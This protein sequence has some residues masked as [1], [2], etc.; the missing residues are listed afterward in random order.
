MILIDTHTHLFSAQF[1][2]DRKEVVN[3]ALKS[4]VEYLLLPNIDIESID[5]MYDLCNEFPQNCLP[6]M[7]LHPGSVNENWEESLKIIEKNLF[8][9]KNIAVGEIGID[10][11]WDTSFKEFQQ[12]VFRIQIEWAKQLKLPIAIHTRQAFDEIFAIVDELNDDSL[13][14]VFHCFNGNLDRAKKIQEYGGFKLGIGGVLTYKKSGMDE[15]LKDIPL[16]MFVLETDSPYLSPTPFRGKRNE[17][18]YLTFI[19][20]K[21]ADVKGTTLAKIAE[22]TS[23]NAQE[24]FKIAEFLNTN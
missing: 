6:M 8:S 18:S 22:I 15:I 4:G 14:G 23:A 11:Y 10:L 19:A 9:K 7:G 1:D 20:E 12:E 21:L 13:T 24:L 5:P 17:S 3:R 16:E 2:E